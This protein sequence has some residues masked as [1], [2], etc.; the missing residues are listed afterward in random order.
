VASTYQPPRLADGRLR[1]RP[2][3]VG[4][5]RIQELQRSRLISATVDVV[6]REGYANLTVARVIARARISRKTFYQVFSDREDCFLAAFEATIAD[7]RRLAAE[8][9]AAEASWPAKVRSALDAL[10]AAIDERPGLARVCVVESL[11]AGDSVL[12]AR[13]RMLERFARALDQ[14][15]RTVAKLA[16]EPP[17]Q[18]ADALVGGLTGLL[19]ARLREGGPE[20]LTALSSEMMSMIVLP[21]LGAAAARRELAQPCPTPS[22]RRDAAVWR[23]REPTAGLKMRLTYRTIR[24]LMAAAAHPGASNLHLAALG[25]VKDAGQISKLMGRLEGHGLLE[26]RGL[27][28]RYGAENAWFLTPLGARLERSVRPR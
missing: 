23:E 14:G 24:V 9:Y 18:T 4:H 5:A 26:N 22:P 17:P 27:G 16:H 11:A 8:A 7:A 21:F 15:G 10:L 1:S 13:T 2:G 3:R 19:F 28:Q 12:A 20:P 6:E 25:G